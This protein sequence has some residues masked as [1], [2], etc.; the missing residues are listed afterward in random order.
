MTPGHVQ[1]Y[2]SKTKG[3]YNWWLTTE[4]I[5]SSIPYIVSVDEFA[6]EL[7]EFDYVYIDRA[8]SAFINDYGQLFDCEITDNTLYKVTYYD[9]RLILIKYANF[10]L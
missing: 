5:N 7:K 8:D 9:N 6:S 10:N 4:E 2:K 1:N 3:Q